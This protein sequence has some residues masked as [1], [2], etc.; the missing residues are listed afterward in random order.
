MWRIL[1]GLGPT[2]ATQMIENMNF[3]KEKF[4]E[5]AAASASRMWKG[6]SAVN[7]QFAVPE[8][9]SVPNPGSHYSTTEEQ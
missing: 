3:C 8:A 4:A 7:W 2:F 1:N 9:G 5:H 6:K